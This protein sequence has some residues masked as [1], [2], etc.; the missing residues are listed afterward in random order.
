MDNRK[1]TPIDL[2]EP[3]VFSASDR[4]RFDQRVEKLGN[5][6]GC[7]LWT[8]DETA[9]GYG[10]FSLRRY[11][12]AAHRMS[13]AMTFGA[14][15][16]GK[17]VCHSCDTPL[18]V[19]PFHLFIGTPKENT[20]DAVSKGRMP[21]GE[22][23]Y[24]RRKPERVPRGNAHWTVM[25]PEKIAGVKRG[26]HHHNAVLEESSV[27]EIRVLCESGVSQ[28]QTAKRFNISPASVC[29]LMARK[30]WAHVV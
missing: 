13:Y 20:Q 7:W 30:S 21:S 28:R 19:N 9:S 12:V 2:S 3:L 25:H 6:S 27:R 16:K 14:I 5:E 10:V 24:T 17:F 11:P 22:R 18:C 23:H 8:G 26:E 4:T 15:P 29:L 1:R